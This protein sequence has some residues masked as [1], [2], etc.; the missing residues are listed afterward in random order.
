MGRKKPPLIFSRE[1]IWP[2]AEWF[3]SWEVTV[4]GTESLK[5]NR[6]LGLYFENALQE[7][8][9]QEPKLALLA[10]NLVVRSKTNTLGEFDL[11]VRNENWTEHWEIAVKFFWESAIEK[12]LI[13]G[14]APIRRTHSRE[15]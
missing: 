12:I 6:K 4:R 7:W 3:S 2:E 14:L 15:N 10:N 8:I 1:N 13:T 5:P 11:I 9:A